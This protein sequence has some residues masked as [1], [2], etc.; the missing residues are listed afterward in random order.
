MKTC[1]SCAETIQETARK[2]RYCG[3]MLDGEMDDEMDDGYVSVSNVPCPKC[4]G[5]DSRSGP[6]PWYLGT[7][8]AMIM[9]AVICNGC[10]HPFDAKKPHADL[11][12]RKRNLAILLNGIGGLGIAGIIGLLAWFVMNTFK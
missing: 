10:D 8:G 9:K 2:C 4:G 5:R 6:W 1:P 11:A 7:V 3:E 12:S